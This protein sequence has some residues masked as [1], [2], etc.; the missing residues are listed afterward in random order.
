MHAGLFVKQRSS[1]LSPRIGSLLHCIMSNALNISRN[2]AELL[3]K[4]VVAGTD[5][6]I[7]GKLK[8][9]TINMHLLSM[10]TLDSILSSHVCKL[11][12][13]QVG[14]RY[15]QPNN[16]DTFNDK[17]DLTHIDSMPSTHMLANNDD[18][19]VLLTRIAQSPPLL[20][21]SARYIE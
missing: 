20:A 8:S 13:S 9:P 10:I 2:K 18:T 3:L 16:A 15:I 4:L 19:K 21:R 1:R 6:S 7:S 5:Q 12:I 17:R 14:L 11:I